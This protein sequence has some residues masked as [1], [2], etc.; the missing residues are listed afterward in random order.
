MTNLADN[1]EKGHL[2]FAFVEPL[3]EEGGEEKAAQQL[4]ASV[5]GGK[6]GEGKRK[7]ER[8]CVLELSG[9]TRSWEKGGG[10]F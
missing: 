8:T 5:K 1:G 6:K 3:R 2:A 9:K 7:T 10:A 4:R